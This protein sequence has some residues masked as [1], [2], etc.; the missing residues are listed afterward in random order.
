MG[1]PHPVHPLDDSCSVIYNNTLYSFT[2]TAF[3]KLQLEKNAKWKELPM[4]VSVEGAAC[5]SRSTSSNDTSAAAMYVVGGLAKSKE[6]QGLQR[7]I[8]ATRTWETI[9]P[10][11]PVTQ[12]RVYH[13]ATYLNASDSIL[14]YSGTQ[15]GKE[16]L[17]SQTFT[18]KASEPYRVSAYQSIAPPAISPMILPWSDSKAIYVGGSKTNQKIMFFD[19]T[20]S[21]VDSNLTLAQ[22]I[23]HSKISKSVIV[24]EDESN[25]ALYTFD[26]SVSPNIIN[27]TIISDTERSSLQNS[28]SSLAQKSDN[29][30]RKTGILRTESLLYSE[31]SMNQRT[32]RISYAASI[33][34]SGKVVFSG[35]SDQEAVCIY[36]IAENKWEDTS[37][38][39]SIGES[40]KNDKEAGAS[41]VLSSPNSADTPKSIEVTP[42]FPRNV[43][44]AILGSILITALFIIAILIFLRSR[45]RKLK[46]N[47]SKD[48][49]PTD[50]VDEKDGMDFMDRGDASELIEE[51]SLSSRTETSGKTS[52][53]HK[54]NQKGV[55]T[56]DPQQIYRNAISKPIP[57]ELRTGETLPS[58]LEETRPAPVPLERSFERRSSGWNRYWSG[59]NDTATVG[60]D[61][62]KP[63]PYMSDEYDNYSRSNRDS[64]TLGNSPDIYNVRPGSQGIDYNAERVAL[65]VKLD[66]IC[67]SHPHTVIDN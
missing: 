29:S 49:N 1:L 6:Y 39:F 10:S 42:Q 19:P 23:T 20:T 17:S 18:I 31:D 9:T 7:Y 51:K 54:V 2:P 61:D 28:S 5:V 36:N 21:W 64:L 55:G 47:V 56:D 53:F 63:N 40:L 62:F 3:Q 41:S 58:Y 13:G 12:N 27:K 26:L 35:G 22:P 33:D 59:E 34:S 66:D 25:K 38:L 32:A 50:D 52:I 46:Q 30:S 57:L 4:G 16:A 24:E 48:S 67:T 65:E 60:N 11:D 37:K 44:G 45:K 43:L 14:I 15:D 8:F